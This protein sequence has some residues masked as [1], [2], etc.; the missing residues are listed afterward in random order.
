MTRSDHTD[1][2]LEHSPWISVVVPVYFG[3]ATVG[4]LV[5]RIVAALSPLNPDFEI[6]LVDDRSPDGSW[7]KIAELCQAEPRVRG[8][9]LS[10]N[11]GQHYAIS[12][13]LAHSTGEWVVVM[14]CDLQDLPE[15]IPK[16]WES[17]LKHDLDLV[18]ARRASRNDSLVRRAASRAFY[19]LF[20]FLTDTEQDSAVGNFG[21]YQRKVVQAILSM[22]DSVRFFPTMSQWVGFK[23][24]YLDVEHSK[25]EVGRSTYNFSRLFRLA[26]TN[27]IAFSNKPLKLMVNLGALMSSVSF[28][29]ALYYLV[30]YFRGQIEVLGFT[31]L[32]LSVWFIGGVIITLLGIIG[33]YLSFTFERVKNRPAYI[34]DSKVNC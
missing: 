27:V 11:F 5:D 32:I 23:R 3:E 20:S 19:L 4:P 26:S 8:L 22:G 30:L 9:R 21:I 7:L 28:C 6:L 2:D 15:E 29:I 12:A 31:S 34:V 14:D 16:L 10:R 24:G 25:R 13:G 1:P 18:F 33:V 17:A